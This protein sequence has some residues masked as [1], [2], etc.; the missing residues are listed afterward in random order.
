MLYQCKGPCVSLTVVRKIENDATKKKKYQN[1]SWYD[2]FCTSMILKLHLYRCKKY[3]YDS[4]VS[5]FTRKVSIEGTNRTET[6]FKD[7]FQK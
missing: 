1:E 7:L 5:L 2:F 6:I 4:K 3:S